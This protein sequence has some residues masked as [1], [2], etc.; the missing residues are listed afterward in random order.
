MQFLFVFYS[1]L[2]CIIILRPKISWNNDQELNIPLNDLVKTKKLVILL[3]QYLFNHCQKQFFLISDNNGLF[4]L[5]P[6]PQWGD[7]SRMS[8]VAIESRASPNTFQN[9]NE[10]HVSEWGTKKR[11]PQETN[12]YTPRGNIPFFS[13][14]DCTSK[15]AVKEQIV[16]QCKWCWFVL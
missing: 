2:L 5:P 14:V 11:G 9:K 13:T 15:H 3:L 10:R 6:P 1:R 8:D 7:K 4:F 12:R 16:C